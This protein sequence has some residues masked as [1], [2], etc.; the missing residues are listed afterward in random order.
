MSRC[1]GDRVRFNATLLARVTARRG[2]T[3]GELYKKAN[4]SPHSGCSAFIGQ[5]VTVRTG[6]RVAEA[7]GVALHELLEKD[8]EADRLLSGQAGEATAAPRKGRA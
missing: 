1:T 8:A 2:M 3:R 4:V 7:L 6:R 5:P